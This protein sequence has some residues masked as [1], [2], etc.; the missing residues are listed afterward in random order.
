MRL[1]D[2]KSAIKS[3]FNNQLNFKVSEILILQ[4][5][6]IFPKGQKLLK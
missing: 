6:T 1:N 2:E 4:I 5:N 3:K